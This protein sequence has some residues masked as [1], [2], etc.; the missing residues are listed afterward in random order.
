MAVALLSRDAEVGPAPEVQ[1]A[2]VRVRPAY[3][4]RAHHRRFGLEDGATEDPKQGETE[5]ELWQVR[6]IK[7]DQS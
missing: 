6:I 3:Q 2:A 4:P 5:S 1:P 7:V